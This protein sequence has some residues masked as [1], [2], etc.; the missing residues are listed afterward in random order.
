[1]DDSISLATLIR[2]LE[3][4]GAKDLL[5]GYAAIPPGKLRQ[6]AI[7][8]VLALAEAY[9]GLPAPTPA[10]EPE[11]EPAPTPRGLPAPP[12]ALPRRT[13][14]EPPTKDPATIAV[15]LRLSGQTTSEITAATGLSTHQIYNAVTAARAAGVKFPKI[16]RMPA[17][18]INRKRSTNFA[19]TVEE[20]S[21]LG[22]PRMQKAAERR[23][24]TLEAYVGLRKQAVSMAIVGASHDTIQQAVGQDRQTLAGWF[25][26]ARAAGLAVP[27]VG[28]PLPPAEPEPDDDAEPHTHVFCTTLDEYAADSKVAAAVDRGARASN[29]SV[30]EFLRVRRD[31]LA[32]V[33]QG[34]SSGHIAERVGISEKQVTNWRT[35]AREGGKLA[36]LR[37]DQKRRRAAS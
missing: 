20:I 28:K 37:D 19:T 3:L 24:L 23:G 2:F 5:V 34:M 4:P 12:A 9:Q 18:S 32:L 21:E 29:L 8:H 14:A 16:K 36:P 33:R 10:P 26:M 11:P 30:P 25:N 22:L 35:R 7:D 15:K 6:T 13:R 31:V 27:Y 1:M 17:G